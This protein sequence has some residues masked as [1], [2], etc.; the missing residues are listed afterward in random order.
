M[1]DL[2]I[3]WVVGTALFG[4]IIGSFLNVLIYRLNTEGSPSPF[5]G[6]SFC[7]HC[8]HVLN[9]FD[10]VPIF[11]FISLNGRC[12]Y[13]RSPIGLRYPTVELVT[14]LSFAAV[15]LYTG[16]QAPL[17]LAENLILTAVLILI[18]FSDWIFGL[19][20]DEAVIML[21]LLGLAAHIGNGEELALAFSSG[22]VFASLFALLIVLTRGRGMGWGD[23]K[24]VL[25]MSLV[26]GWP[27]I[28]LALWL[29]FVAGGIVSLTL[30]LLQRKKFNET[31]ALGPFLVLGTAV[32]YFYG[33]TIISAF[34]R[35]YP[36]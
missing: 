18:F 19:I 31:I 17:L 25:V 11:S 14:A 29:G 23:V 28:L 4:L 34:F 7:P 36:H 33:P 20:P 12:R 13:C 30:V 9:W 35:L 22:L 5:F 21:G 6:R 26:L 3:I 8:Q 10:L 24:L 15:A 32:A 1:A 16:I 2:V 27:N